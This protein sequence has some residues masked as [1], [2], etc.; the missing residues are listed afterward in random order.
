[1]SSSLISRSLILES[2]TISQ[3]AAMKS[4]PMSNSSAEMSSKSSPSSLAK[5]VITA[6]RCS[7]S[8][9]INSLHVVSPPAVAPSSPQAASAIVD[10]TAAPAKAD[11]RSEEHTSELQ[12]RGHLVC[13][14]L[15][16]K[17]KK[18]DQQN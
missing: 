5:S 15:L 3:V 8:I 4:L 13:R 12:S 11:K 18:E 14:L 16:E 6:R 9:S 2:E 1:M 17:K 10:K 7:A